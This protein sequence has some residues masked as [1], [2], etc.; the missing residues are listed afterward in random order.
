MIFQ[1]QQTNKVTEVLNDLMK[2]NND[3]IT[4]YQLALTQSINLDADLQDS[5]YEIISEGVSYRQQLILMIRKLDG[6]IKG[7]GNIIG[8]IYRAWTDLKVVFA[9]KTQK[10]IIT[11]CLYN[12]G[13]ALHA[14]LAALNTNSEHM[15]P[16]IFV[17]ISEQE[18][19]LKKNY[20]L[21]RSYRDIRQT[22][23]SSLMYFS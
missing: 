9:N 5:F 6:N 22:V 8:K 12:E 13:I 14:Y 16:E 11:S 7:A 19:G 2:I 17:L 20:D 18:Q 10:A 21:L 1:S 4:G 3:R 23:D 15:S